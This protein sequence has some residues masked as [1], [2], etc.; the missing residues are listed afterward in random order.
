MHILLSTDS[1][2]QK[3]EYQWDKGAGG[4]FTVQLSDFWKIDHIGYCTAYDCT[5]FCLMCPL[6]IRIRIKRKN[7]LDLIYNTYLIWFDFIL[8]YSPTHRWQPIPLNSAQHKQAS[9]SA[10]VA[11]THFEEEETEDNLFC[12]CIFSVPI[13]WFLPRPLDVVNMLRLRWKWQGLGGDA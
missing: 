10:C 3:T 13:F 4:H 11:Y 6:C 9:L 5:V 2:C 1:V 12:L 8:F 7:S